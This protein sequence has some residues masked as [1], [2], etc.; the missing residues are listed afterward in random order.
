M[1][2]RNPDDTLAPYFMVH[3]FLKGPRRKVTENPP[4]PLARP[5]PSRAARADGPAGLR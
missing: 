1:S 2:N 4:R 5:G 3:R